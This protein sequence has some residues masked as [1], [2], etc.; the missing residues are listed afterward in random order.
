MEGK[1][2][3]RVHQTQEMKGKE[4]TGD[5]GGPDAKS[6]RYLSRSRLCPSGEKGFF[7][8]GLNLCAERPVTCI[9]C[10]DCLSSS[11]CNLMRRRSIHLLPR[12]DGARSS[13]VIYPANRIRS[14]RQP[15]HIRCD[16]GCPTDSGLWC[17]EATTPALSHDVLSQRRG[18]RGVFS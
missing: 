6:G 10:S 14:D 18:W 4:G 12:A 16:K 9:H 13:P 5:P 8:D 11:V 7:A 15:R 17:W 3:V 1:W 2:G